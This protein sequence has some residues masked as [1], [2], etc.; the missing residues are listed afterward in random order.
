MGHENVR[1]TLQL[2]VRKT[3]DPDAILGVLNDE[4]D[5]PD[6]DGG[7]TVSPAR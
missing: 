6:E 7:V 3:E 4:P 1:T 5:E 2:Y